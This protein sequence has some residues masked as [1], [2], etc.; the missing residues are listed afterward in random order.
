MGIAGCKPCCA[1]SGEGQATLVD[2]VCQ[3]DEYQASSPSALRED[4]VL[5]A[6]LRATETPKSTNG[7]ACASNSAAPMGM[8]GLKL[9][10]ASATNG[11]D[12]S[13]QKTPK[14]ADVERLLETLRVFEAAALLE[15]DEE[16]GSL[17]PGSA[18][19]GRLHE[20]LYLQLDHLCQALEVFAD[21]PGFQ[22][23]ARQHAKEAKDFPM[24]EKL[25]GVHVPQSPLSRV[26]TISSMNDAGCSCAPKLA[27]SN[28]KR[29]VVQI[30]F[31]L[32]ESKA[33]HRV[34]AVV[35]FFPD[36]T[37]SIKWTASELPVPFTKVL[38][39]V[40]EIDLLGDLAPFVKSSEMLHQFPSNEADRL[41]RVHS[42]PPI[43]FVSGLE[44]TAQRFG[45]DLL[46]TP[47]NS[48]GLVEVGPTWEKPPGA[49]S[50]QYRGV[51]RPSPAQKGL[52]QVDVKSTIVLG[53]P[54]GLS[55]ELT[56]IFFSGKGDLNVPRSLLPDWL[57]K[58][59]IKLI[60]RFLF[61]RA[62]ERVAKF[63]S[64]EHGRRF[65]KNKLYEDLNSRI[66]EHMQAQKCQQKP[67]A[68]EL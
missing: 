20:M 45:F 46:E 7:D 31:D 51:P 41:I 12:N 54:V 56:T 43:P 47:W 60:G 39:L 22:D 11:V 21:H 13:G 6:S 59:L 53:R 50:E 10:E 65:Q 29:D 57:I 63:D 48:F 9:P 18:A 8:N 64:S 37:G 30:S 66:A 15:E 42:K 68:T 17:S 62:L 34:D 3:D 61:Q 14:E 67:G 55:G 26:S 16:Q 36:G 2:D 27:S 25:L 24:R 4:S 58:W 35:E 28:K 5:E 49:E 1:E 52:K 33:K 38:C 32:D 44:M 19:T 23:D 40:H